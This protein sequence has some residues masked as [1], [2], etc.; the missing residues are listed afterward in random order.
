[1]KEERDTRFD[2]KLLDLFLDRRRDLV[3]IQLEYADESCRV[4]GGGG[5][6]PAPALIIYSRRLLSLATRT[7]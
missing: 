2:P 4:R 6:K 1:M 7:G 5:G 3:Q